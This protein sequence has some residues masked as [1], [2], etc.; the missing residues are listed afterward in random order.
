MPRHVIALCRNFTK[1]R[2][3]LTQLAGSRTWKFDTANTKATPNPHCQS[4]ITLCPPPRPST[5]C[6]AHSPSSHR[7]LHQHQ[8]QH[9]HQH[10]PPPTDI[11]SHVIYRCSRSFL[12]VQTRYFGTLAAQIV[13]THQNTQQQHSRCVTFTPALDPTI[14]CLSSGYGAVP[15]R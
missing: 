3:M 12:S 14:R 13:A 11:T 8:H 4:L 10:H 9:Q 2:V 7:L 6:T 15:D 5:T 1:L